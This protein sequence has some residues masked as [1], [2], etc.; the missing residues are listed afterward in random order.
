MKIILPKKFSEKQI[1]TFINEFYKNIKA[2]PNDTYYFDFSESEWISNQSLL[3]LSGLIKYLYKTGRKFKIN[4]FSINPE[5]IT[6]RQAKQIYQIWEVWKLHKIFDDTH[7]ENYVENFRS[8]ER[9]VGKE[10]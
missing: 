9:R 8:E 2:F 5:S 4:L 6:R 1:S 10:C 3:L 7:F